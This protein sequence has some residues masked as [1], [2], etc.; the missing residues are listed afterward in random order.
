[1]PR[2]YSDCEALAAE[3]GVALYEDAAQAHG[4][5]LDGR[6]VGLLSQWLLDQAAQ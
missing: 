2:A 6:P 3:R 5:S 1:M 4:A